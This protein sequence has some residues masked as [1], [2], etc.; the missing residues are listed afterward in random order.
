MGEVR[1]VIIVD[2]F[3]DIFEESPDTSI[4]P[5]NSKDFS[6]IS[7]SDFEECIL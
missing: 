5:Y 4:H 7:V 1:R 3:S 6:D 2:N